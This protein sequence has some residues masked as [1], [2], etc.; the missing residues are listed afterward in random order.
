MRGALAALSYRGAC[1]RAGGRARPETAAD[2]WEGLNRRS[3][4]VHEVHRPGGIGAGRARLS[5]GHAT[6][7]AQG[8]AELSAQFARAGDVRQR[9]AARRIWPRGRDRGAV[10]RQHH[11]WLCRA[12]G[13]ALGHGPGAA[14]RGFR[15]DAWRVGCRSWPLHFRA[16]ARPHQ[17]ARRRR[18]HRRYGARSAHLDS[19][20]TMSTRCVS[21]APW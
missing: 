7:G 6:A 13:S 18:A 14:R 4:R 11:H 17:S 19:S 12:S 16:S 10:R 1:A 20:S 8:R 21:R 15:P 3:I 5:R 2:P 9:R